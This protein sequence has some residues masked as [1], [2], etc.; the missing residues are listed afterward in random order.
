MS[1]Q[2]TDT[3]SLIIYVRS[4]YDCNIIVRYHFKYIVYARYYFDTFSTI[5]YFLTSLYISCHKLL[6]YYC[7]DFRYY[8]NIFVYTRFNCILL[9]I[10]EIIL[11]LL[12]YVQFLFSLWY[13]CILAFSRSWSCAFCTHT[14]STEV[15]ICYKPTHAPTNIIIIYRYRILLVIVYIRYYCN[16]LL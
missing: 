11:I 1:F 10:L 7:L 5:L 9:Y 6:L 16:I 8:G 13:Y 14:T 15:R 12:S 2:I 3:I 4:E